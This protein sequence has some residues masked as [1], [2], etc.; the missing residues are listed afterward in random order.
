LI[1]PMNR[2]GNMQERISSPLL[3]GLLTAVIVMLAGVLV[4]SLILAGTGMTEQSL[5]LFVYF[6]HGAALLAGG[7]A[8]GRRKGVKGWYHGG[9]LGVIYWLLVVLIGFLSMNAGIGQTS[10]MTA[11]VCFAAGAVGGIVGVNRAN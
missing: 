1:N 11:V 6:I 4:V 5:P 10:L 7:Y 9:M 8:V 2:M 3:S